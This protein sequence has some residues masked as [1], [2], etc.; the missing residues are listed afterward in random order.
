[1][2]KQSHQF[3]ID[4]LHIIVEGSDVFRRCRGGRDRGCR[5]YSTS[6]TLCRTLRCTG[7]ESKPYIPYITRRSS[8]A[9]RRPETVM[10]A[11]F[12]IWQ[13][14]LHWMLIDLLMCIFNHFFAVAHI[15]VFFRPFKFCCRFS[16]ISISFNIL[17]STFHLK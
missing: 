3:Q 5:S 1:M 9:V 6:L 15:L 10:I 11:T 16:H 17:K 12:F 13:K 8:I 2:S 14:W 7:G 4:W